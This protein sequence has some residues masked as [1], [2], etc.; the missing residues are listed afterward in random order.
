MD[1]VEKLIHEAIT[2]V[3]KKIAEKIQHK[4]ECGLR[5]PKN[6]EEWLKALEQYPELQ[7]H[8]FLTQNKADIVYMK[9][10][11]WGADGSVNEWE[12]CYACEQN[13]QAF[14][15]VANLQKENE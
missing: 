12:K 15:Q 4:C 10:I 5:L 1:A 9:P 13:A 8:E 2:S 6:Q 14:I 11:V 3:A 7:L